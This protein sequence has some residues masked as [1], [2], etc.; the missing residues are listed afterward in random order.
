MKAKPR[1]AIC[2]VGH[3]GKYHAREF[4]R[5]GCDVVAILGTSATRVNERAQ[6]LKDDFGVTVTGYDDVNTMFQKEML[7]AISIC[8]PPNAHRKYI[9]VAI[10]EQVGVFVEKPFIT[11]TLDN[12]T[13][14]RD[15]LSHATSQNLIVGMNTQWAFIAPYLHELVHGDI[16]SFGMRMAPPGF[17]GEGL[18]L[19]C[20][21]HFSSVLIALC[22]VGE[23]QNT[24]FKTC[25]DDH[26]VFVGEYISHGKN[27]QI[28]FDWERKES[29]PTDVHFSV[30]KRTFIRHAANRGGKYI[31]ALQHDG[32]ETL[33][34]DFLE[35]SIKNFVDCLQNKKT[36][37]VSSECI[38]TNMTIQEHIMSLFGKT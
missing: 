37:F 23:L 3:I 7:D 14:S 27:I 38:I 5:A 10:K 28:E 9:E 17:R 2:G 30:N 29:R 31:Q 33:I 13:V 20:V 6:M 4:V 35:E 16:Q 12:I 36:P 11:N 19:E 25:T 1:I 34:P 26:I 32:C 18:L 22:G 8:T 15:L 21:P 24:S